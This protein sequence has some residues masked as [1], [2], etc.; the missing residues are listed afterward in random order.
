MRSI[1]RIALLTTVLLLCGAVP[2]SAAPPLWSAA[3]LGD[4][5]ITGEGGIETGAYLPGTDTPANQCHRSRTSP[6]AMLA[7]KGLIRLTVDASCSGA[8]TDNLIDVGQY[9]EPPQISRLR[10]DV[11]RLY[12]MIGGN[13][14]GFGPLLGCFLQTDCDLTTVPADSIGKLQELEPKL[15]RVFTAIR[16]KAPRARVVVQLYPGLLPDIPSKSTGCSWLNENELGLGNYIQQQL[17]RIIWKQARAHG[18]WVVIPMAFGG[19]SLCAGS[20][21]WFYQPGTVPQAAAAHPNL[22]GRRALAAYF[23]ALTT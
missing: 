13:D 5:F 20:K 9:N 2:A 8:T 11:D 14:I 3:V 21:S 22:A 4:S 12:A 1:R 18:F 10:P 7:T 23:A 17:N 6:P 16:A 15:D 19:H